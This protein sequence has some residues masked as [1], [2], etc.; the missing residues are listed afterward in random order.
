MVVS[1]K[2]G[3]GITVSSP[4]HTSCKVG[5]GIYVASSLIRVWKFGLYHSSWF[6]PLIKFF[7]YKL[8]PII[9]A[10]QFFPMFPS[11]TLWRPPL[12]SH[13]FCPFDFDLIQFCLKFCVCP[14]HMTLD[15]SDGRKL[16]SYVFL[17][18]VSYGADRIHLRH[19]LFGVNFLSMLLSISRYWIKCTC[20]ELP[21]H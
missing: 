11:H 18:W 14:G 4:F 1:S 7:V 21:V 20:W 9:A 5:P 3:H 15:K 19:Y 2:W 16:L 10:E 13:Y 8:L 6:Y 12:S 17:S